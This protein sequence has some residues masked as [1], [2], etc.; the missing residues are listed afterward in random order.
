MDTFFKASGF[1]KVL[2]KLKE[3]REALGSKMLSNLTRLQYT[4]SERL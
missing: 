4:E 2:D 1:K 3:D